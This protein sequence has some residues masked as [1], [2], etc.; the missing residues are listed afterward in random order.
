LGFRQGN[1]RAIEH[2]E[3]VRGVTHFGNLQC[4]LTATGPRHHRAIVEFYYR[5][6][7]FQHIHDA[8]MKSAGPRFVSSGPA[9]S[10]SIALRSKI[11]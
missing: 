4:V 8:L 11:D 7:P 9:F 10:C 1:T 6:R 2:Y 5:P 3:K